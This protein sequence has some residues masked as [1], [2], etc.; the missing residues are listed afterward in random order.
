MPQSRLCFCYWRLLISPECVY[1][2]FPAFDPALFMQPAT[3]MSV[4]TLTLLELVLGIDNIIFIAILAEKLPKSQ[5]MAAWRLGLMCAVLGRILLLLSIS[6]LTRLTQPLLALGSLTFSGKD[7]VLLGGGL[8]LLYKSGIELYQ[9]VQGHEEEP[10]NAKP[11]MNAFWG[12]VAQ[13]MVIDVVFALDSIITAVGLVNEIPIMIVAVVASVGLM[14]VA[15]Q[16]VSAIMEKYPSIKVLGLA[17]L[18]VIGAMLVGEGFHAHFDKGYVYAALAFALLVEW[19]NI[20]ASTRY[21]RE[22]YNEGTS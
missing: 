18:V 19:L 16:T 3:W 8:F 11:V 22:A 15:S 13:I 20:L 6:W 14:L 21:T 17:F 9:K 1:P 5:R 4:L 2:M 7:L 12:I 10:V